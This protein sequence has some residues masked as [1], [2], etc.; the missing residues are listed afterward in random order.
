MI[1]VFVVDGDFQQLYFVS[2]DNYSALLQRLGID[3]N[4]VTFKTIP[5]ESLLMLLDNQ[6]EYV[7]R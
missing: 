5:I 3:P 2:A 7:K 4:R 1:T 6:V